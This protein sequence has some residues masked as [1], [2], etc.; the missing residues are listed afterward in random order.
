MTNYACVMCLILLCAKLNEN[1]KL[2]LETAVDVCMAYS[3]LGSSELAIS[4]DMIA[5]ITNAVYLSDL[6]SSLWSNVSNYVMASI[7]RCAANMNARSESVAKS[8]CTLSKI[9]TTL[10]TFHA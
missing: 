8:V 5:A 1:D 2:R 4:I 3:K 6:Q 7:D 9:L 10:H